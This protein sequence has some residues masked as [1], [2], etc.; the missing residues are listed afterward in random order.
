MRT[1][2]VEIRETL[3]LTIDIE[4]KKTEE[5]EAEAMVREAYSNK[6]CNSMR[7]TSPAW[8]LLQRKKK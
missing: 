6:E 7:N 4:A 2:Q 5:A 3:R 1:Y 8:I